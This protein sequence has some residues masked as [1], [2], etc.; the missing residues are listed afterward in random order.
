MRG[1]WTD[2]TNALTGPRNWGN[3]GIK[4]FS[5]SAA[6]GAEVAISDFLWPANVPF[7]NSAPVGTVVPDTVTLIAGCSTQNNSLTYDQIC[8]AVYNKVTPQAQPQINAGASANQN[9]LP[10]GDWNTLEIG[11]MACRRD[12]V[13]NI[14]KLPTITVKIN[15]IPVITHVGIPNFSA[16]TQV[17]DVYL[18]GPNQ[19]QPVYPNGVGWTRDS[20][21]IYLQEHD[22]AVQFANVTINPDWLPIKNGVLDQGWQAVP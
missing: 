12:A 11:F 7:R 6:N 15:T 1:T 4:I 3:S 13:G 9:P 19:G 20:G 5:N 10:S 22:N 17:P 16:V 8:G 2:C 14:Q 18:A 21:A